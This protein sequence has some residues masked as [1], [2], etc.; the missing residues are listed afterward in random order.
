M[1]WADRK[2]YEFAHWT[3]GFADTLE[4][5]MLM[6]VLAL[7][8]VGMLPFWR[9]S[10]KAH[11]EP[12][13]VRAFF[14]RRCALFILLM[15]I[16]ILQIPSVILHD[17]AYIPASI[18]GMVFI[19]TWLLGRMARFFWRR[20]VE[21]YISN[22][23]SRFRIAQATDEPSDIRTEF[24]RYRPISKDPRPDYE[25]GKMLIGYNMEG[26]PHRIS[27][28]D[29]AS[30]NE[31]MIGPTQ[32]GKG[33]AIG[34]QADQAV[35]NGSIVIFIDPKPDKYGLAI[36]TRA[37][38]EA[39]RELVMIDLNGD[40]K[41]DRYNMLYNGTRAEVFD[42]LIRI[43]DLSE[44]GDNADFYKRQ[45][46]T[47]LRTIIGRVG[48]RSLKAIYKE[49]EAINA[50]TERGPQPLP[51]SQASLEE[52]MSLPSITDEGG[53]NIGDAIGRGAVIY[54]RSS[55]NSQTVKLVTKAMI[56][57]ITQTIF[58]TDPDNGGNR[59]Q[60]IFMIVDEARFLIT[61]LMVNALATI[62]GSNAHMAIAYQ[63]RLDIRNIPDAS[64]DRDS[65]QTGI[66][67]NCKAKL[68]YRTNDPDT[69]EWVAEHTGEKQLKIADREVLETNDYGGETM[70]GQRMLTRKDEYLIPRNVIQALPPCVAV[71]I[72]PGE[73]AKII[74]SVPVKIDLAEYPRPLYEPRDKRP[75][76]LLDQV[77]EDRQRTPALVNRQESTTGTMNPD[78]AKTALEAIAKK[79]KPKQP[80]KPKSSMTPSDFRKRAA[81]ARTPTINEILD[82]D[83]AGSEKGA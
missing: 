22:V 34:L 75:T 28:E 33:V 66:D 83:D 5:A 58:R 9:L 52:I 47:A 63:S 35:R 29:W 1:I 72:R 30:N 82:Q 3:A 15:T 62:Q 36:I 77:F 40:W 16:A 81:A 73:M 46:R 80:G 32:T 44:K 38:R 18:M 49:V 69:T 10:E 24:G 21:A 19:A 7:G 64:M 37:C 56:D 45:E 39:S 25:H 2:A 11:E 67:I 13:K 8:L 68:C 71:C 48:Y 42:R 17:R 20:Y 53:V 26:V 65:I 55:T 4:F 61:E 23:F 79:K 31:A 43:C 60:H 51:T 14:I 6:S 54:I 27:V 41:T 12:G 59:K 78:D 74:S 50:A 57:D 76:S 70:G